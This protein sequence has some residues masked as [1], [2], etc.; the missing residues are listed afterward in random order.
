MLQRA[1]QPQA[2]LSIRRHCDRQVAKRVIARTKGLDAV[3]GTVPTVA[4]SGTVQAR[5]LDTV[6]G[7]GQPLTTLDNMHTLVIRVSCGPGEF[8]PQHLQAALLWNLSAWV[9]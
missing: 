2:D 7:L 8:G 5:S 3:A 4:P 6:P 9:G 1:R